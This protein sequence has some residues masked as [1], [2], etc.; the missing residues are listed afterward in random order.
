MKFSLHLILLLLLPTSLFAQ[1]QR[2]V[3]LE[4]FTNTNCSVCGA[5]NPQLHNNMA[6]F[7]KLLYISYYPSRPYADCKLNQHNMQQ[8]DARTK[9]YNLFGSTPKIAIQGESLPQA[10]F[11]DENLIPPYNGQISDFS[12]ELNQYL[13]NGDSIRVRVVVYCESEDQV[14]SK[15]NLYVALA[16]DTVFYKGRN[17]ENEHYNVFRKALT[18]DSGDEIRLP[19]VKGDSIVLELSAAIHDDWNIDRMLSTAILQGPESKEI[20]QAEQLFGYTDRVVSR[21]ESPARL[22]TPI[23]NDAYKAFY[24]RGLP[25]KYISVYDLNG[26]LVLRQLPNSQVPLLRL[27]G[28]PKGLL[29]AQFNLDNG[30]PLRMKFLNN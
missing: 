17:S 23:W 3:I 12:I 24:F 26:R 25:V 27:Y 7:E 19:T 9:F 8:N 1:V 21:N 20:F 29:I 18:T 22:K 10:D 2:N 13:V 5:R 14:L 30:D 15:A 4:H 6:D 16:E 28:L 11:R